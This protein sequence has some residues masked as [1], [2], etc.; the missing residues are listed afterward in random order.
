MYFPERCISHFPI[1][2][3]KHAWIGW[4]DISIESTSHEIWNEYKHLRLS[5]RDNEAFIYFLVSILTFKVM[6][7]F[8]LPCKQSIDALRFAIGKSPINQDCVGESFE[9]I[10]TRFSLRLSILN[11]NLGAKG[12]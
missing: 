5:S 3:A 10:F 4:R 9:E 1:E 7:Q 2:T 11:K 6:C 8:A 12:S